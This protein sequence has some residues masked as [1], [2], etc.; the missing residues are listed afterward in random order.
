MQMRS[1]LSSG[2][3]RQGSP[4]YMAPE[5]A[6]GA[7]V[8][9]RAD[10]YAWGVMAYEL[11]AGTH[12]FAEQATAQRMIVAHLTALAID[13]AIAAFGNPRW[14]QG[15]IPLN[16]AR[17]AAHLG[18]SDRAVEMLEA[19]IQQAVLANAEG[20][21]TVGSDPFLLP[22]RQ[23]ARFRTLLKPTAADGVR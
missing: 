19:A 8:D 14:S 11:L 9:I 1:R 4:A 23:Y 15:A 13:S 18:D 5:Q 16:R 7:A 3:K 12:P 21:G 2:V 6:V 17:I 22:L 20:V 10:L